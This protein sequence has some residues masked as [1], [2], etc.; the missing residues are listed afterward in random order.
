MKMFRRITVWSLCFIFLWS[1]QFIF[2]PVTVFGVGPEYVLCGVAALA[3][4]ENGKFAAIYGLVFGL[5]CDFC[6]SFFFGEKAVLFMFAGWVIG[7]LCL[8]DVRINFVSALLFTAVPLTMGEM[9]S[10]ICYAFREKIDFSFLLYIY[11]PKLAL[12]VPVA[13]L[14]WFGFRG[15]DK[16][17]LKKEGVSGSW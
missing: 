16:L 15:L 3:M 8:K 9:F 1:L 7:N 5:M 11:L 10:F 12:T 4:V 17:M 2:N 14:V 13:L 6:G